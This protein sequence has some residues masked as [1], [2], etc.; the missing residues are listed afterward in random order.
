[1]KPLIYKLWPLWTFAS[2]AVLVAIIAKLGM[3]DSH[4]MQQSAELQ[5]PSLSHLFGTDQFGRSLFLRI[6]E[7]SYHVFF[8]SI[9]AALTAG[10]VGSALGVSSIFFGGILDRSVP[11]LADFLFS[12]PDLLLALVIMA[13]LGASQSNLILALSIVYVPGFIRVSRSAA[14]QIMH[15]DFITAANALGA[16]AHRVLFKHLFPS[17]L[18]PILLQLALT[19]GLAILAESA[20]SF[21]GFGVE[22]GTP[23]WGLMLAE[24]KDWMLNA[25]WI[26]FFPG[27]FITLSVLAIN[28]SLG[29]ESD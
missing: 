18:P 22:P 16:P 23:T 20:L 10:V 19:T 7:G 17:C 3:L 15:L 24:G 4:S 14:T 12:I 13:V 6:V 21:I 8:V 25:W 1:M 9:S 11:R 26:S 2:L 5:P 29:Q 27:L 28:L